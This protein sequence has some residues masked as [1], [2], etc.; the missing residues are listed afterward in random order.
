MA[1]ARRVFGNEEDRMRL[2]PRALQPVRILALNLIFLPD[3]PRKFILRWDLDSIVRQGLEMERAR[4]YRTADGLVEDVGASFT[5]NQFQRS[6]R[7]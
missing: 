6:D 2:P 4:R 7:P 5:T 3:P 1:I